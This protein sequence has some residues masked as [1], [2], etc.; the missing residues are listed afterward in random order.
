M[1]LTV[2]G[3]ERIIKRGRKGRF[4]DSDG[5]YLQLLGSPSWLYRFQLDH[6]KRWM[7]LGRIR[8]SR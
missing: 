1:A 4:F 8:S 3:V 6:K 5:L 7:G 2:K